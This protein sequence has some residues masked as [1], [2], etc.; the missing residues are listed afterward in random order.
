LLT[1]LDGN[2]NVENYEA[3]KIYD[4]DD[5]ETVKRK[6]NKGVVKVIFATNRPETLDPA[7]LRTGRCDRKIFIDYPTKREKRLIFQ[8]CTRKMN[9]L[10]DVDLEIFVSKN[11][12]ISGAD[13]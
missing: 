9:L 10:N 6:L 7:L 5:E 11:A 12:K 4:Y 8:V 2:N 1:Q 13:I 3:E